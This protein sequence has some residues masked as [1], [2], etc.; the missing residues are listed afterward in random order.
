MRY[1]KISWAAIGPGAPPL[2]GAIFGK[3]RLAWRVVFNPYECLISMQQAI[4][5]PIPWHVSIVAESVQASTYSM[6][7]HLAHRRNAPASLPLVS[8]Y[9]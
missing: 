5:M 2:L 4:N 7:F 1:Q 9:A 6:H 8:E 3:G